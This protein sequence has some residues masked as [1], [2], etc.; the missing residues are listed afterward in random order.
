MNCKHASSITLTIGNLLGC[1][2][3]CGKDIGMPC[4]VETDSRKI[5]DGI[6][7]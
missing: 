6:Y 2:S 4:R 7:S 3:V 1:T 5:K